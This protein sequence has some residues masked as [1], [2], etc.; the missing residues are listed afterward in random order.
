M[1]DNV[2]RFLLGGWYNPI[3]RGRL[4]RNAA[5]SVLRFS[6]GLIMSQ[7]ESLFNSMMNKNTL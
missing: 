1:T 2:I 3:Q 6:Q 7:W 4:G 5:K